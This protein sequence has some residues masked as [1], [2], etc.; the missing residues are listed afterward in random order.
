M[1]INDQQLTIN[2]KVVAVCGPTG[3]GKTSLAIKLCQKF[4]GEI[5]SAD[6][7]QIYKYMD[8]GTGKRPTGMKNE[9]LRIKEGDG[10]WIVDG[11]YIHLYDVVG[12]DKKF[13]VARYKDAA[14]KEI[15]SMWRR[16]KVPF[17]VGG[18]GFYIAA[19]LGETEFPRI[20]PDWKLR[21][22]LEKFST[23]ELFAKLKKLNPQRA[24]TVDPQN[25]RRLIRAIEITHA[26]DSPT[27]RVTGHQPDGFFLGG[28]EGGSVL[29]IGL[30]APRE[31]LYQRADAWAEAVVHDGL[32]D[33]VQNLI[34]RGYRNTEPPKGIIYQTAVEHLDGKITREEMLQKIKFDLHGYIR[35]QLTWFKR[36][37]NIHWFDINKAGFDLEIEEMVESYLEKMINYQPLKP[38]NELSN[39]QL[40][41]DN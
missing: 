11:V 39:D 22:D 36:D 9:E 32:L 20:A 1:T 18:T 40:K 16:G 4:N 15:Q 23:E 25:P 24:K 34:D 35:R 13:S 21:K 5:V 3:T 27:R 10:Y 28:V 41:I 31:V 7:R 8:I 30:T 12:P 29:K 14:T 26:A 19:V 6:S 37:K 17:L 33:E 2:N 38:L